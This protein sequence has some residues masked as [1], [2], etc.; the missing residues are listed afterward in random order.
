[1]PGCCRELHGLDDSVEYIVAF[2]PFSRIISTVNELA[3]VRLLKKPKLKRQPFAGAD[4]PKRRCHNKT[5]VAIAC[6]AKF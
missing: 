4:T 1:M 5:K 3:F 2:F 6:G